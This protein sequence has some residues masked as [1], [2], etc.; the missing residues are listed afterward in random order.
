MAV[1]CRSYPSK[2]AVSETFNHFIFLV[3]VC[4]PKRTSKRLQERPHR[5]FTDSESD[6]DIDMSDSDEVR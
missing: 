1:L 2:Q 5:R 6:D 4:T 3:T